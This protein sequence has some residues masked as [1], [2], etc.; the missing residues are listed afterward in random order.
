MSTTDVLPSDHPLRG[1]RW[2]WPEA[3][4][5]LTNCYAQFRKDFDLASVPKKAPF[6][7]TADKAYKLYV[8]GAYVCRGPAR[9][10]Q[11]HWP[12][13]EVD[14]A[15]H[16]RRGR[17]FI[18]VVAYNPGVSTFQYLHQAHA[19]LLCAAR[20]GRFEL[21]S[22]PGWVYR[23]SAAHNPN[24]ARYSLQQDFQ[25][26]VD[27]AQHD[28]GWLFAPECL[29]EMRPWYP[30]DGQIG[31]FWTDIAFSRAPWEG[32]EPRGIPML[33]EELIAPVCATAHAE[34]VS[35]SDYRTRQNLS[36]GWVEEAR[37]IAAWGD[38]SDLRTERGQDVFS[39]VLDPTGTGRFRAVT[40][41]LGRM[42]VANLLVEVDGARGGEI[43]DFQH[44]QCLRQGHSE[45]LQ[46]GEGCS[47]AL[48]NR[49]R[50][51][52]GANTHE[53]FHILGFRHVTVIARDLTVPLKLRVRARAVGYPFTMQGGF[54][55]SDELLNRIH[56]ACRATQQL[57]SLDAY[58]DTPWREQAQ[59]W[60]D[61]RVQARNTFH[62]D[63]DARLLARG[64]RSIAGQRTAHGLTYGHAPTCAYTCI[65]PDFAL[66]WLLTIRDH[67]WQTGSTEMVKE[68]WPRMQEVLGYFDLPEARGRFGLLRY[69]T[70]YWLF[71][72]WADL[73]KGEIPTFL[74][75]WY[76][77]ALRQVA[78]CLVAARMTR[79]AV[80]LRKQAAVVERAALA[81]LFDRKAGLFRDGLDAK[82][83]PVARHS[84][85]EQVLALMT[86]LAP[87][88]HT[89]MVE[90]RLLPYLRGEPL[91]CAAP[92]A[93]WCTYLLEE[94]AQRGY[95]AEAIA[96]IRRRWKPM[97]STG[98]TWEGFEWNERSGASC[99]HAWTAHPS[100]HLVNI[101]AGLWQS[102]PAWKQVRFAPVFTEG[103][104]HAEATVPSPQGP[105][106]AEWRR[107]GPENVEVALDLPRGVSAVVEL[108]GLSRTVRGR[109]Q[110]TCRW[111]TS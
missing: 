68:Q 55:C 78:E 29:V 67:W 25:E 90:R 83:R 75:L 71:E 104:D 32:V 94:A 101:L 64:I 41:D 98:T 69:D 72:D 91:A 52:T 81:K 82:G 54:T 86:G 56:A 57:C 20:W 93:F 77:Y 60:G 21:V 95:G 76:I 110:A 88:A 17:N 36:W 8:N 73:Y 44:D 102:A 18:G 15:P 103:V 109:W 37:Q 11:S 27:L 70:R 111:R 30:P 39:V 107:T 80:A 23:R 105:I 35:R 28:V 16:L 46:P 74:N 26:D 19:G 6:F 9:G 4:L 43:L 53:F 58:V 63:G 12:Y 59:W 47:I 50:L 13:D 65:L 40:L 45:H 62:L 31:Q 3:Y 42:A 96:F 51:A 61:A 38:G 24:T 22:G 89:G 85:H 1:A 2:I 79:E 34:G 48:A 92:S 108:P 10:Y 84:V 5:Y 100:Y 49:L 106:V 7:I 14:L 99:S 97:L 66:T 87:A 33:R